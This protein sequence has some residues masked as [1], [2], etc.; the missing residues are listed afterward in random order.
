M[1]D[2]IF[3]LSGKS[4]ASDALIG[5]LIRNLQE[6]FDPQVTLCNDAGSRGFDPVDYLEN[7]QLH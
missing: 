1:L 7:K 3:R 2:A 4:W 6:L 5:D